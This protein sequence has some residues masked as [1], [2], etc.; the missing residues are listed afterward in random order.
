[1]EAFETLTPLGKMRRYHQMAHFALQAYPLTINKI[2]CLTIRHNII[3]R[4]DAKEGIFVLRIGYPEIRSALMVASEMQWLDDMRHTV[5]LKLSYPIRTKSNQ[6]MLSCE[7]D[8]IPAKRHIVVMHWLKGKTVETTPTTKKLYE[9]GS[10]LATLHN[11]AQEYRPSLPF[12]DYDNFRCDEWGG[13]E[14]LNEQ[15]LSLS[16]E[17]QKLF[18]DAISFSE[19][20]LNDWRKRDGLMLIHADFHLKNVNWY[21]GKIAVF[22]F[23]DCR[24]GH[25]LQDWAVILAWLEQHLTLREAFMQGYERQRAISFSNKDLKLALVHRMMVGLTFVVNYRPQ[26][27]QAVISDSYRKLQNIFDNI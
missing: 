13:L 16:V 8:G 12:M 14:Y 17:Q 20:A 25:V 23:D 27:A 9:M 19:N 22:D 6:L 3:F 10:T 26:K 15:N 21:R 4:V 11:F 2:H 1:M 5:D 7:L 24:W 18:R